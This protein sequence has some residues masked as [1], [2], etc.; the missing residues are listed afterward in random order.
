MVYFVECNDCNKKLND[1]TDIFLYQYHNSQDLHFRCLECNC[2][3]ISKN[4]DKNVCICRAN[5][6]EELV[7]YFKNLNNTD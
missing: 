1:Y 2:S 4:G 6:N 5:N 7:E 3:Y